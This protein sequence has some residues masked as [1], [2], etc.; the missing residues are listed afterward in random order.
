MTYLCYDLFVVWPGCQLFCFAIA[1]TLHCILF[2]H[3]CSVSLSTAHSEVLPVWETQWTK[4]GLEVR[5]TWRNTTSTDEGSPFHTVRPMPWIEP[6]KILTLGEQRLRDGRK[7]EEHTAKWKRKAENLDHEYTFLQDPSDTWALEGE[8][9]N[10][11]V[12]ERGS[13]IRI[14]TWS[15]KGLVLKPCVSVMSVVWYCCFCFVTLRY[16]LVTTVAPAEKTVNLT[17]PA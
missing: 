4:A 8:L 6:L 12:A 16:A 14:L 2:D 10:C 9:L 7:I 3:F 17:I 13:V 1:M 15:C 11:I 5:E